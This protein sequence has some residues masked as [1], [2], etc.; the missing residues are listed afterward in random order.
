MTS[1]YPNRNN[2]NYNTRRSDE[3]R[4]PEQNSNY[5]FDDYGSSARGGYGNESHTGT[6]G[7]QGNEMGGS[8]NTSNQ[9]QYGSYSTSR[10]YGNM[11]S[12]G[13][14]QGFGSSRGGQ[15]QQGSDYNFYSGR[16]SASGSRQGNID[17]Y[18]SDRSYGYQSDYDSHGSGF[19][20]DD[21]PDLYGSDTSRRFQGSSQDR[22]DFD[23]DNYNQGSGSYRSNQNADRG[24]YSNRGSNSSS[25]YGGSQGNYMG[26]GY[27]RNNDSDYNQGNYGSMG[28][29]NSGS[30]N[31]GSSSVGRSS[32]YSPNVGNNYPNDTYARDEFN[33]RIQHPDSDYSYNPNKSF[34]SGSSNDYMSSDNRQRTWS[35][36][37]DRGSSRY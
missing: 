25:N 5:R 15:H 14:A 11:G 10:N 26:S 17:P 30:N 27:S 31:Y 24:G 13:G 16:G 3:Y 35:S 21:Q 2:S 1:E 32:N 28:N 29:Y 8:R 19:R 6:W 34:R 7:N 20:N 23:A 22:Y 18:S 37:H 36:D 33:S 9:D 12:Y 4:H